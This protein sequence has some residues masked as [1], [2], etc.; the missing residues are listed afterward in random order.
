M[1]DSH[2]DPLGITRVI[3][4]PLG[5]RSI[6]S[7][8]ALAGQAGVGDIDRI[9]YSVR[10]LLESCL[11]TCDGT[12]VTEADIMKLASYD[13]RSVA[14]EEIPFNPGRVVLQDLL[15]DKQRGRKRMKTWFTSR[16]N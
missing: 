12:V 8:P 14:Q 1:A 13:A 4:T 9:P 2:H 15:K 7:L 10:V 11:R 6:A 3:K 16:S 5:E